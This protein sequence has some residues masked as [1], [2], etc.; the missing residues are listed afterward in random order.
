MGKVK[1]TLSVSL[2]GPFSW[3]EIE[4]G[5]FLLSDHSGSLV[6]LHVKE[7]RLLIT[8]LG[9]MNAI[10]TVRYLDNCVFYAGS[11]SGPSHLVRITTNH[12]DIL[13]TYDN[14]GPITCMEGI[15]LG[16]TTDQQLMGVS[17]YDSV[18]LDR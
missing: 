8:S 17:G 11:Y 4:L 6:L 5:K 1:N 16:S 9:K 3:D 2:E 10:S 14:T 18:G 7:N 15:H 13:T 12:L